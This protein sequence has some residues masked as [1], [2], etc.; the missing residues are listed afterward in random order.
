MVT[1]LP[2][3]HIQHKGVCKGCSLGKN[4]KGSFLSSDNRSKEILDLMHSDVWGPMNVASLNGY[5]YYVLFTDDYSQ[6]TWIYFLKNKDGV[7]AK[8]QEF[9][10]QVENLTR[11]KIKVIRLDNGG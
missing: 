5:L 9:K 8:F 2:E 4:V 7:L 1:S 10:S 6:K 11:R 3:I